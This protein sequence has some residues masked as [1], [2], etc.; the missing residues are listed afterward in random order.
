MFRFLL[1]P[2]ISSYTRKI[3]LEPST[4]IHTLK[5]SYQD[6]YSKEMISIKNGKNI[7][8]SE[9]TLKFVRIYVRI[10]LLLLLF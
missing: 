5:I 8:T 1:K 4:Q 10:L 9:L 7:Q 6:P 2:Q 3:L